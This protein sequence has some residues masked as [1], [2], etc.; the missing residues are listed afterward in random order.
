MDRIAVT[1]TGRTWGLRLTVFLVLLVVVHLAPY[2]PLQ[3]DPQH[4]ETLI[5]AG[6]ALI[7]GDTVR[8][9]GVMLSRV[10]LSL[11]ATADALSRVLSPRGQAD[12]PPAEPAPAPSVPRAVSP[13]G[14]VD[15]ASAPGPGDA[16]R[17]PTVAPTRPVRAEEG[18]VLDCYTE[19]QLVAALRRAR[20]RQEGEA[21]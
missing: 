10:G 12:A 9:M 11:P 16:P 1:R 13:R 2:L 5:K 4:L 17:R 18:L 20:A 14:P 19:A 7:L 21:G 8:P 3:P 15:A 6:V